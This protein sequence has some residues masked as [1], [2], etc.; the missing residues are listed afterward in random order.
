MGHGAK[1]CKEPPKENIEDD[2]GHSGGGGAGWDTGASN[3]NGAGGTT[4]AEWET[5][6][7]APVATASDW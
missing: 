4:A 5:G 1:R 7:Q 2:F 6:A 3:T